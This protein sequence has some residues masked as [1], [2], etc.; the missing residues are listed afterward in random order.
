MTSTHHED[1]TVT[2]T[3][4]EPRRD[5]GPDR[6][7]DE[8]RL[9][10]LVG[11]VVVDLGGLVAA[12]LVLIGDRTGLW[13]ALDEGPATAEEL[14]R[15]ASLSERYVREWLLAMAASDYV[16]H[17]GDG[18]FA[19]SPEQRL[20]FC[21]PDSPAFVL[22]GFQNMTAATRAVDRLTEAFRTGEGM[23]WHEHHPDMFTGTER[24]FRPSYL[25]ALTSDW[26]PACE[27]LPQRLEQ[28]ARVADVGCGFGASTIVLAEAYPAS[29]FVGTDYHP[30][31]VETARRRAQDAGLS[32]R[33]SFDVAGATE[34]QGEY[35]LVAMFDCLHDMPD[36]LGALRA[37]RAA[38]RDDGW[39]LLVEPVAGDT[40][41]DALTPVGRLYAAASVLIC[42]PS[43]LSAEPRT[44]LG[45]QAGPQRTL[46]LAREAG[47]TT[48]R[49]A[50]RTPFNVVY[51]LRP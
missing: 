32:E 36:P 25:N 6:P 14:A 21:E 5:A 28:G 46:G 12:P 34:L 2:V 13:T 24:F 29:T 50:T 45:N 23:G 17:L 11:K 43:G 30:E 31:S 51:E 47:F 38:V 42:L 18:T 40:V 4:P 19:L 39:V 41:D 10:A 9:G 49:E 35:D 27:G 3:V 7:L 48:A 44:G 22:G 26:V 8:E 37:A 15:R 1:L 33:C 16:D 20:M